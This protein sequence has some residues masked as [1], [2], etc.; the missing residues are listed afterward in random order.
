MK[1]IYI[2]KKEILKDKRFNNSIE[3]YIKIMS[4]IDETVFD[5]YFVDEYSKFYGI[6]RFRTEK[7]QKEYFKIF[8]YYRNKRNKHQVFSL[9]N[10][11]EDIYNKVGSVELS[12]AT[13]MLHSLCPKKYPIYD[14]RV[15][16]VLEI[17]KPKGNEIDRKICSACQIYKELCKKI[18]E[19]SY[20][21]QEYDKVFRNNVK[22]SSKD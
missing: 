18:R 22:Y 1:K 2:S 19:N 21:S 7:W 8:K 16:T 11:L 14:S 17:D 9:K 15:A 20:L 5:N 6:K 3:T 13:K 4:C 10:I 12:F